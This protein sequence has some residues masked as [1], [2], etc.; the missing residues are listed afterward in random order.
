MQIRLRHR[1]HIVVYRHRVHIVVYRHKRRAK[2]VHASVHPATKS[3]SGTA[4]IQLS[5]LA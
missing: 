4:Y 1:V 2:D 5:R 3:F